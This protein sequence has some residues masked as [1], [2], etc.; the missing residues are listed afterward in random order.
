MAYR[1]EESGVDAVLASVI[2][3]AAGRA[4]ASGAHLEIL[5]NGDVLD[6]DA[7]TP[8]G[9]RPPY[10]T[11]ED[12]GAAAAVDAILRDHPIFVRALAGACRAG[13]RVVW[14]PGNHDD[15]VT[16]PSVR[17]VVARHHLTMGGSRPPL[18]ASWIYRTPGGVLAEHGHV[19]DASSVPSRLYPV[20][21]PYGRPRLEDT[22]STAST[23]YAPGLFGDADPYVPDPFAAGNR[24]ERLG[25][26]IRRAPA[27]P[28][29]FLSGVAEYLRDVASVSAESPDVPKE[30]AWLAGVALEAGLEL[31]ALLAH[32]S[33]WAPKADAKVIIDGLMRVS[34]YGGELDEALAAAALR[35]G[36]IHRA[37]AVVMG[38]THVPKHTRG[39]G[40]T[41]YVNTG[42]WAPSTTRRPFVGTFAW[43]ESSPGV[44]L[45][46]SLHHVSADG[47]IA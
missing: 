2:G 17:R 25:S 21:D 1:R 3:R 14:L 11:R 15:H 45:R 22:V 7:P 41:I 8:S 35:A 46:A 18:F 23:K 16:L 10:D 19:Y 40:G 38:H 39:P 26:A 30:R 28:E 31:G 29:G 4:A 36:A 9:A 32:R 12:E 5:L 37:P 43:F 24:L 6:P 33:M 34:D 20:R 27:G 47:A 13:A 44:P 42:T